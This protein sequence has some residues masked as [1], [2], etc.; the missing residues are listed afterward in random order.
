MAASSTAGGTPGTLATI[1]HKRGGIHH[2]VGEPRRWQK[3]MQP[4]AFTT[5]FVATDYR[6]ACRENKASFG[7]GHFLEH[8]RLMARCDRALARLL[9][10]A[11]GE[12]ELPGLFTQF[13][14]HTQDALRYGLMGVWVA[15]VVMGFLLHGRRVSGCTVSG[16]AAYQQRPV[17]G[18]NQQA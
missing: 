7:L 13:K 9:P 16:K 2:M 3:A 10:M 12:T 17:Y 6:R 1:N 15:V 11:R 18:I 5:G 14:G 8:A 4:E